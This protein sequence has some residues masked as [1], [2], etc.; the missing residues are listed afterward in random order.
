MEKI[1]V[2]LRWKLALFLNR[3][4]DTCWADLV[5]WA[6]YPEDYPFGDVFY[7]RNRAG[8]CEQS[9]HYNYCGKCDQTIEVDGGRRWQ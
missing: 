9:G 8:C 1:T 6:V 3:Y 7:M 5:I 2:W 4:A